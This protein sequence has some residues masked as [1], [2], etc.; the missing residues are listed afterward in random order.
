MIAVQSAAIA[1]NATK[2]RLPGKFLIIVLPHQKPQNIAHCI[3]VRNDIR[4]RSHREIY[5][6]RS[7]WGP[8]DAEKSPQIHRHKNCVWQRE[9]IF[10]AAEC[11]SICLR[12]R[13]GISSLGGL[14]QIKT[15]P[16][17]FRDGV[18][19]LKCRREISRVHRAPRLAGDQRTRNPSRGRS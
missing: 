7:A 16:R 14:A 2:S 18:C 13:H 5:P 1:H 19:F 8:N 12:N 17:N 3:N 10:H 6:D 4:V 11:L 9:T 15:P